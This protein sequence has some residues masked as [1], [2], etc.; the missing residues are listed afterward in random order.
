MK[1]LLGHSPRLALGVK[2]T[3]LKVP[4]GGDRSLAVTG[5]KVGTA[6]PLHDL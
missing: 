3:T 4:P 2:A 1:C 6:I 5:G